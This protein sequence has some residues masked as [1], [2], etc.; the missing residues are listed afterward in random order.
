MKEEDLNAAGMS[1]NPGGMEVLVMTASADGTARIWRITWPGLVDHF[2]AN[3]SACLT[4]EQRMSYLGESAAEA[5]MRYSD[6]ELISVYHR[7]LRHPLLPR[8]A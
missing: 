7:C 3:V 1:V 5:W 4:P 2:R 6:C 8:T